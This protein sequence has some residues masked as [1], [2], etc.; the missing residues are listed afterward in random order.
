[1]QEKAEIAFGC[2]GREVRSLC[3]FLRLETISEFSQDAATTKREIICVTESTAT[4]V[5]IPEFNGEV[6]ILEALASVLPQLDS[7]DEVV[8]VDDASTDRTR[9]L[10][11]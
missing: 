6:F 10:L 11:Y 2:K 8:V 1:M 4:T 3:G 9:F 5:I 7:A